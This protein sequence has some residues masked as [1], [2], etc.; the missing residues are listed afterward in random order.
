M[1]L[2]QDVFCYHEEGGLPDKRAFRLF[3]I[4][5]AEVTEAEAVRLED[6]TPYLKFG[7]TN[8]SKPQVLLEMTDAF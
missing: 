1:N 2:E 8:T 5:A 3:E 6:G 7:K 4:V